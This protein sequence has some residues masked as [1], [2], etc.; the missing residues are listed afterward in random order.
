MPEHA[1]AV[2]LLLGASLVL[3]EH[4]I[5]AH[6][7]K[8]K[9]EWYYRAV[10]INGSQLLA[11]M[12]VD[13][14]WARWP[15]AISLVILADVLSPFVGALLAYV[16]FTIIIYWWHRLRHSSPLMWRIF[17]QFHHNPQRIHTLTAYYIHPLDMIVGLSISNIILFPMLGLGAQAAGWYTV[18]TGFA[19]FFI[20]AN[21]RVP[22][23]IGYVFQTPEM[24]RLHHKNGHH[25]QNY[26]D[27]VC[28][29]MIFGTYKNPRQPIEHCGFD[30]AAELQLIPML[31]GRDLHAQ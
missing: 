28:W 22:R 4:L 26:S 14:L 10:L 6:P 8:P 23:S 1:L 31:L 21:I 20:H 17:H 30:E 5:P 25:A 13:G 2:M 7:L 29:D 12:G 27:I 19:G 15:Y 18:I 11:F 24:H 16:V 3:L 9:T